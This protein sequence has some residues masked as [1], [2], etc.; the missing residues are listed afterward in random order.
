MN[1]FAVGSIF[2]HDKHGVMNY[3]AQT[4]IDNWSQLIHLLLT[5]NVN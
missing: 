1:K 2:P 5:V 3:F 4:S